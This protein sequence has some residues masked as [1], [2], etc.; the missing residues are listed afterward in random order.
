M[1]QTIGVVREHQKGKLKGIFHCF[2]DDEQFAREI[3]ELGFYLGIGGTITYKNSKLPGVL[4]NIGLDQIVLETDAP[5]LPPV[6]FRGK[7]NESSYIIHVAQK[8][9]GIMEMDIE[10]IA[11]IT[12]ANALKIFAGKNRESD[13]LVK[14]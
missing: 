3:V 1:E 13:R 10:E 6:P 4:K 5:Y 12:T 9:A 11:T 7:R 8:L 2:N 14:L